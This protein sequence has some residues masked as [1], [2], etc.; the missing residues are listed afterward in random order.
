[1]DEEFIKQFSGS[2]SA[3]LLT[4]LVV[5]LLAIVKK[6]ADR[7]YHHSKC[8][9]CCLSVELDK[10]SDDE[11]DLERGPSEET[12]ARMPQLYRE[13]D[14]RVRPQYLAPLPPRKAR[15]RRSPRY[16]DVAKRQEPVQEIRL[17]EIIS[18]ESF[19]RS[20]RKGESDVQQREKRRL[21]DSNEPDGRGIREAERQTYQDPPRAGA[22]ANQRLRL[23][24]NRS[25]QAQ[26]SVQNSDSEYE[27]NF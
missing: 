17:P 8:T 16:G 5:G 26:E 22:V 24:K 10:S 23:L 19:E 4:V 2:A 25:R 12:K 27:D 1:M 11:D 9:S 3:N 15:F 18:P 7:E 13:Y 14:H 6:C 20:R 21:D